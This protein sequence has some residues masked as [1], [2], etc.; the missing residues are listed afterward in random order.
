[1]VEHAQLSSRKSVTFLNKAV[2]CGV[3]VALGFGFVAFACRSTS[4]EWA[5]SEPM[6]TS[7]SLARTEDAVERIAGASCRRELACGHVGEGR[8]YTEA[9]ECM[10]SQRAST[11]TSIAAWSCPTGVI[12]SSLTH[13]TETLL[14]QPCTVRISAPA[15]LVECRRTQ[16][17]GATTSR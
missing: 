9:R 10:D 6:L 13:C 7:G 3:L 4:R 8:S 12:E 2:R 1:M 11:R 17:C 15:Q 5:T 14:S 16:L